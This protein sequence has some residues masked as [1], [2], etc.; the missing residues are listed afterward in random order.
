M[1][2]VEPSC[3][4]KLIKGIVEVGEIIARKITKRWNEGWV[5]PGIDGA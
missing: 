1:V 2:K 5:K 3:S 4:K